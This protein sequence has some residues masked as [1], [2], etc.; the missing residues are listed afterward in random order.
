MPLSKGILWP[1]FSG[2]PFALQ[3]AFP[4]FLAGRDSCDYYG[5]SELIGLAS[6]RVS[7]ILTCQTYS[8][9]LGALLPPSIGSFPIASRRERSSGLLN[10]SVFHIHL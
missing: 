8:R 10:P 4:T 2:C 5:G 9:V 7:R 1:D 3:L 6:R